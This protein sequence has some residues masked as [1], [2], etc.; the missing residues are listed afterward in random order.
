[1]WTNAFKSGQKEN[2]SEGE[3]RMSTDNNIDV[4]SSYDSKTIRSKPQLF[5]AATA[6]KGVYNTIFDFLDGVVRNIHEKGRIEVTIFEDDILILFETAV[7][8]ENG[9]NTPFGLM[10]K[11]GILRKQE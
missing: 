9:W 11:D 6:V 1:M 10:V 8:E 5:V 4:Y 2:H 3:Q 7:K